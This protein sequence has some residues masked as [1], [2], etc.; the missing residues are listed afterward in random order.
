MPTSF[1]CAACG[2]AYPSSDAPPAACPICQDERQYVPPSGQRW[3]DLAALRRSHKATFSMEAALLGLGMTPYFAIGQRALLVRTPAGNLLWDLIPLIDQAV[4]DLVRGLG[5]LQAIAISHPHYYGTMQDW[6]EAFGGV[7]VH[8]HAADREHVMAPGPHVA[9]WE[10]ERMQ[11]LPGL[12]LVR[13]GGHFAGGTVLHVA[14]A[15]DGRGAVLSGDILQ[16]TPS[17][18]A[19]SFMR[20]YPNMIPLSAGSVR[21]VAGALEDLPFDAIY[22]AFWDR[23]VPANGKDA[24]RRSV[25]RYVRWLATEDD[26]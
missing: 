18:D 23:V 19:V 2:T 7:P 14:D 4:V 26:V 16:V 9:F 22:G 15:H 21:R 10:G 3:T 11:P 20:S 25:E 17:G 8:L 12:T 1:I 24:L 13:C 6:S 5:G